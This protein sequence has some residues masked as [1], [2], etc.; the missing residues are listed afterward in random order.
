MKTILF[1]VAL[2]VFGFWG[3]NSTAKTVHYPGASNGRELRTSA[4][5]MMPIWSVLDNEYNDY[6]GPKSSWDGKTVYD[7][8]DYD[9]PYTSSRELEARDS[10]SSELE[11]QPFVFSKG[12]HEW[13]ACDY[14]VGKDNNIYVVVATMVESF[15]TVATVYAVSPAGKLLWKTIIPQVG[16]KMGAPSLDFGANHNLYC[17]DAGGTSM[18][19]LDIDNYGALMHFGVAPVKLHCVVTNSADGKTYILSGDSVLQIYSLEKT[20]RGWDA[21]PFLDCPQI[22]LKNHN[23]ATLAPVVIQGR[24]MYICGKTDIYIISLKDRVVL[25]HVGTRDMVMAIS[26]NCIF[27]LIG[28]SIEKYSLDGTQVLG[29]YPI[30][31]TYL[32]IQGYNDT[33]CSPDG[34]LFYTVGGRATPGHGIFAFKV[35]N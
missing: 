27:G 1:V 26:N 13:S 5:E 11:W 10:T 9:C 2:V 18:F 7:I 3:V 19:E 22:S 4:T 33:A 30:D 21:I 35:P 24:L 15:T 6:N 8:T 25:P 29:T 17:Y 14:I 32:N 31:D 28:S 34:S 20:D 23:L 12:L 16:L